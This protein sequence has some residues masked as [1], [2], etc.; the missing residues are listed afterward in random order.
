MQQIYL[1][2]I[3]GSYIIVDITEQTSSNWHSL[4]ATAQEDL[5]HRPLKLSTNWAN[6][7][8]VDIYTLISYFSHHA[9]ISIVKIVNS[10]EYW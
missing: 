9:E 10:Y 4:I 7:A 6:I 2:H 3:D 8:H 5:L 1:Q